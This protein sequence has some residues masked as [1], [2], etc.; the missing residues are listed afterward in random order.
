MATKRV[1]PL[2][3]K[4]AK[5]KKIAIGGAVLLVALI[6]FQGPK[7][8][9]MLQGP[10]PV[11]TP[12]ATTAAP[13]PTTPGTAPVT[14]GTAAGG[15]PTTDAPVAELASVPDSDPAP[16][17]EQ[18]QLATFERFASKDPF[19]QQ[20][21][22]TTPASSES[23]PP[24]P[25]TPSTASGAATAPISTS[26]SPPAGSPTSPATPSVGGSATPIATA[27][28]AGSAAP[29]AIASLGTRST[30]SSTATAQTA[31]IDVNGAPQRVS[32]S[33][34]F[35]ASNPTFTLVSVGSGVAMIGIAGGSYA[36]GAQ[37]VTLR[38]GQTLTLV[39][40]ADGV[41]YD[42]RLESTG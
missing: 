34:S 10:Q 27:P 5:Q 13:A 20:V 19:V 1:D 14:G 28:V 33:E 35:P 21:S 24:S 38:A 32:V 7:T 23:A 36:S 16:D 31:T 12:A 29:V 9:K 30:S 8:M 11:T 39:N 4:E 37:T 40:T 42:L 17:G 41:R 25:S 26:S 2:K 6:A 22:E 18:G 3:A 15:A